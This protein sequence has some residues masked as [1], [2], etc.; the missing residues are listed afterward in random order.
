MTLRSM[1]RF[2]SSRLRTITRRPP[3]GCPG[4]VRRVVRPTL[5]DD[6]MTALGFSLSRLRRSVSR[7][8]FNR[9]RLDNAPIGERKQ[10]PQ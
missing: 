1:A 6:V 8:L 4:I 9:A 5:A 2:M 3:R 10:V 7:H